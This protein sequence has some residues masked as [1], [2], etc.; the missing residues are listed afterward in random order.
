MQMMA[1]LALVLQAIMSGLTLGDIE[2]IHLRFT[3]IDNI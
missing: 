3:A 2:D 1:A